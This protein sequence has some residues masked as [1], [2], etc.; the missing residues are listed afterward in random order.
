M[1]VSDSARPDLRFHH[2]PTRDGEQF[3]ISQRSHCRLVRLGG[4]WRAYLCPRL[5]A[6]RSTIPIRHVILFSC[7]AQS[8]SLLLLMADSKVKT[9]DTILIA[10]TD[11][12]DVTPE[13]IFSLND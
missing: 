13:E 6:F 8:S 1:L 4:G 9:D 12:R 11:G 3:V 10:G 5:L 7:L 2:P